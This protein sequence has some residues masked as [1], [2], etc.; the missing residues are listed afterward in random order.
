MD[1]LVTAMALVSGLCLGVIA[2]NAKAIGNTRQLLTLV[3]IMCTTLLLVTLSDYGYSFFT[4]LA[5]IAC[6]A[7]IAAFLPQKAILLMQSPT[8]GTQ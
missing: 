3:P 4:P 7:V 1:L 8:R 6:G 5:A 2:R